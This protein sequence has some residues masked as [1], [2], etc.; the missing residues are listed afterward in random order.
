MIDART[1]AA[2]AETG[3]QQAKSNYEQAVVQVQGK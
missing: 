1:I 3:P 2:R